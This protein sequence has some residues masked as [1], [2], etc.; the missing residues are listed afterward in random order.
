MDWKEQK[1]F[2]NRVFTEKT[3]KKVEGVLNPASPVYPANI[4]K[5]V[6]VF[7]GKINNILPNIFG[8]IKKIV[9]IVFVFLILIFLIQYGSVIKSFFGKR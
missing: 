3:G 8:S 4:K 1:E 9:F 5:S 2:N 7:A 6:E